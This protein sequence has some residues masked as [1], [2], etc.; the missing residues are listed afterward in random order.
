[1][2]GPLTYEPKDLE[3]PRGQL[4]AFECHAPNSV[5]P[6]QVTWFKDSV[7]LDD[8][9]GVTISPD[10]GTL[11]LDQVTESDNGLYHCSLEN[12][13]GNISS[14]EAILRVTN[15]TSGKDV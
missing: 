3:I 14:R 15:N 1:M 8:G 9:D 13:A 5:P 10:S 2:I 6:T 7:Q 4:A 12:L 11:F